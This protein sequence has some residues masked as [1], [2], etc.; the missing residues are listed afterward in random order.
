MPRILR[1]TT[2]GRRGER[3]CCAWERKAIGGSKRVLSAGVR[4]GI[5]EHAGCCPFGT[6]AVEPGRVRSD[7]PQDGLACEQNANLHRSIQTSLAP[8]R[9][10]PA[11]AEVMP[12]L[13]VLQEPYSLAFHTK[14]LVPPIP[15]GM[16]SGPQSGPEYRRGASKTAS[17]RGPWERECDSPLTLAGHHRKGVRH[18]VEIRSRCLWKESSKVSHYPPSQFPWRLIGPLGRGGL[19]GMT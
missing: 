4:G 15:V 5:K 14:N 11:R 9:T 2:D 7:S 1:A 8:R 12:E 10:N 3:V 13:T 16:P 17:P 18:A 19:S 6:F